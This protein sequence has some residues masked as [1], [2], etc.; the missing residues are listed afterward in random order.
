VV[1][2]PVA[3]MPTS[4]MLSVHPQAA[5]GSNAPLLP[6]PPVAL[7]P[8][9][10]PLQMAFPPTLPAGSSAEVA[11]AQ[12]WQFGSFVCPSEQSYNTLVS[13]A[14]TQGISMMPQ[15]GA[16]SQAMGFPPMGMGAGP[17]NLTLPASNTSHG[18]GSLPISSDAGVGSSAQGS[19]PSVNSGQQPNMGVAGFVAP[20]QVPV[21]TPQSLSLLHVPFIAP[22]PLPFFFT[23]ALAL[24]PYCFITA[25][26]LCARYFVFVIY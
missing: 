7:T 16:R 9:G 15:G 17:S 22:P 18:I 24:L 25:R 23:Q 3:P 20:P 8:P 1:A 6:V 19:S 14:H 13:F 12:S 11:P 5:R 10:I 2:R 26:L 21:R 4:P